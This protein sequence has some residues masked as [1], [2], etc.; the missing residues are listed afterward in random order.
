MITGKQ[1]AQKLYSNFSESSKLEQKNYVSLKSLL[2]HKGR[3]IQ[4][5]SIVEHARAGHDLD[6]KSIGLLAASERLAKRKGLSAL[7]SR[8]IDALTNQFKSGKDAS[9]SLGIGRLSINGKN[10]SNTREIILREKEFGEVKKENKAAQRE[11]KKSHFHD[12]LEKDL[13]RCDGR[14]LS[15]GE[16]LTSHHV[17][18]RFRGAGFVNTNKKDQYR[19]K[20]VGIVQKHVNKVRGEADKIALENPTY[21]SIYTDWSEESDRVKRKLNRLNSLEEVKK[22]IAGKL[23]PEEKELWEKDVKSGDKPTLKK[24]IQQAKKYEKGE[25]SN[26]ELKNAGIEVMQL[27][28]MKFKRMGREEKWGN[29]AWAERGDHSDVIR[30]RIAKKK[31]GKVSRIT[32]ATLGTAALVGGGAYL[33]HRHNKKKKEAKQEKENNK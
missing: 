12:T 19:T 18:G 21:R 3:T 33:I 23:T 1:F 26:K 22:K 30:S 14:I 28:P 13:E 5:N 17:P 4:L 27:E 16:A 25:H 2:R 8:Q 24:M 6:S 7:T 11:W 9:V 31:L 15:E 32:G 29:N 20:G 10:Y